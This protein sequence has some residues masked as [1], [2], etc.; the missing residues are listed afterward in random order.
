MARVRFTRRC[1]EEDLRALPA[2]AQREALQVA[3]K[4][5][6]DPEIGRPLAAPFERFRRVW[7]RSEYRLIYTY[8]PDSETWWIYLIGKRR[9]GRP[10][11]VYELLKGLVEEEPPP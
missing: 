5:E 7:I 2:W 4:I 9:P 3:R 8:D 11:D 6:Q 10:K 1:F